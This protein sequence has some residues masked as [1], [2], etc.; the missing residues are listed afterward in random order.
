MSISLILRDDETRRRVWRR[1]WGFGDVGKM[2]LVEM[3]RVAK[4]V[5]EDSRRDMRDGGLCGKPGMMRELGL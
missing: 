5:R 4:R 2:S 3:G 1:N